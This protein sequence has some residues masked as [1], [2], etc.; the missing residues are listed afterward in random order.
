MKNFLQHKHE[1]IENF[2]NTYKQDCYKKIW[3]INLKCNT[4]GKEKVWSDYNLLR[5]QELSAPLC[6]SGSTIINPPFIITQYAECSGYTKFPVLFEFNPYHLAP[7]DSWINGGCCTKVTTTAGSIVNTFNFTVGTTQTSNN[8]A[9]GSFIFTQPLLVGFKIQLAIFGDGFLNPGPAGIVQ[10]TFDITTGT[11]T[12]VGGLLFNIG[13]S[14]T[15]FAY[16]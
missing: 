2:C 3:G 4:K 13:D 11:I 6:L 12:L 16:K 5:Y 15:I 14:Y 7:Q 1:T 9:A 10:Y 8:P